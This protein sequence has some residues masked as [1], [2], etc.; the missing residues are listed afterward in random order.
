MLKEKI[1]QY[2]EQ[3]RG[4]R[5]LFFFDPQGA[6][7]AGVEALELD[8]IRVV[9]WENNSFGLKVKFHGEWKQDKTFLYLPIKAPATQQE[10][11]KF[12]L[13]DIL[14]ANK[15]LSLD[16]V[17]AFMDQY[18][19]SRHQKNLARK[20]M[21]EL[22]Y[23]G[24]QQICQP[25][26]NSANFEEKAI[27]KGI[28][29]NALGFSKIESWTLIVAK[30]LS[31]AHPDHEKDL[32]RVKNKIE[33][34]NLEER[35]ERHFNAYL[36]FKPS[37]FDLEN[38]KRG[39]KIVH[40]NK[41][42]QTID[43]AK[44]EDPYA[45]FKIKEPNVLVAFNQ[46]LQDVERTSHIVEQLDE[47]L[48]LVAGEIK[49]VLLVQMYGVDN[50]FAEYTSDMIWEVVTLQQE[51][52]T[53]NPKSVIKAVEA[54]SLQP[55]IEEKI[56]NWLNFFI[57]AAKMY[58]YIAQ[59]GT[60][61]LDHPNNYIESYINHW[62]F[63]DT[64]YRKAIRYF[65]QGDSTI[66]PEKIK[67]DQLQADLN[68]TYEQFLYGTNAEW[69]KCLAAFDF[70][71][72]KIDVP[73]QFDFYER[74]VAPY[75]QKIVVI[76][77]DGLRYEAASELL[78]E[79][80]GDPNNTAV[81]R[82]QMAS[83]PSKTNIGMAQLL[84]GKEFKFNDGK[85][86]VD[87]KSTVGILDRMK[88]LSKKND[89]SF[90][91]K[92]DELKDL[93][94]KDLREIFKNKVVY[95]YHD[96]IDSIGDKRVSERR[97]FNAVVEAIRELKLFIP[98]LHHSYNVAKV[99]ITADHGFVY[100]DRGIEEK[101]KQS[102]SGLNAI[103]THNRFEIVDDAN[104]PHM[105]YKIPLSATT[106]FRED[107]S[108]ITPLS[109]NRYKKQGVGHQFVHGGGAL[110]ELLVPV[111]ESSR[112]RDKVAKKVK[113]VLVKSGDLK[114]VSSV[115]RVNLLQ[116]KK[117]SGFEKEL[118]VAIGIYKDS[119]LVSNE[120]IIL[121]NGTSDAPS[122]R[123]HRIDLILLPDAGSSILKLKVFDKEDTDKL[124]PLIEEIVKNNTLIES[125][126]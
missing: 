87:G 17:G 113:T 73:K 98:K 65:H 81:I 55:N 71:Y 92:F 10:Y 125:D 78:S 31:F 36:G 57:Q 120:E 41:L 75:D 62:Q 95:I 34:N 45:K 20:Y 118:T 108:V 109:I 66:I 7:K 50:A 27:Q 56:K 60:Y 69:L 124:N 88:V 104:E 121:M 67:L 103:Q 76:I 77:S 18:Q 99:L 116:E 114:I 26:L 96:V 115:L 102:A 15:E 123:M 68:K 79:M 101:D 11:L 46:F 19:L 1:E 59:I 105:G 22:Q 44:R 21:H 61:T 107:L 2:F 40:Y 5:V 93:K 97:T 47:A 9:Y 70:D 49:G 12:P 58:E 91:I 32:N 25:I 85:I 90:A 83:I 16:D 94:V 42:T 29:C 51:L 4:L 122:E 111:I 28:L 82:Y 74:E 33:Q 100:N 48:Q 110:Q 43:N 30:L 35:V 13:L 86:L 3:H 112:K 89:K 126:F 54:L 80:H 106:K 14:V 84:P 72:N 23:T 117:V 8:D 37:S 38:F 119:S 39:L 52:L 6:H 24:V 63:I 53:N 64:Y